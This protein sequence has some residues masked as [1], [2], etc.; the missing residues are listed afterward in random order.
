MVLNDCEYTVVRCGKE[1][2]LKAITFCDYHLTGQMVALCD[3]ADRCTDSL[4]QIVTIVVKDGRGTSCGSQ[5]IQSHLNCH[6]IVR[7]ISA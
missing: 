6:R 3:I 5:Q 4:R 7:P 2:R 1:T